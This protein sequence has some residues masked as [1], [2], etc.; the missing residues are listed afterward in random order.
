MKKGTYKSLAFYE[1]PQMY[2]YHDHI[3]SHDADQHVPVDFTSDPDVVRLV[4]E[5]ERLSYGRVGG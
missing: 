4:V 3:T 1:Q 5:G 2:F